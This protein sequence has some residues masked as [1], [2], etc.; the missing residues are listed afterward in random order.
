MNLAVRL[1][2]DVA[3]NQKPANIPDAWPYQ[4]R[5]LGNSS[6]IPD[7]GHTWQLMNKSE[8]DSYVASNQAAYD[9]WSAAQVE[10][11]EYIPDVT[12]RQIRQALVLMNVS[13]S[14]ITDA[15]AS[16]PE[17]TKSMAQ[18]EWEYS[19]AFERNRPLVTQVGVMLG[20]SAQQLNDLW[21]FA[22][23]L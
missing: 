3:F 11:A 18:I 9:T 19:L 10:P 5:E 7:D 22:A 13:M 15:L 23:S 1:Y 16:L 6:A 4:V 2:S 20:W 8:Y 12:P 14:Q 21:K 17:P